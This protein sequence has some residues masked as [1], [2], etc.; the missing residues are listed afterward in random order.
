MRYRI[1]IVLTGN[2][3]Q[4]TNR[5]REI[6]DSARTFERICA[7]HEIEH[8]L[9]KANHPWTTGQ[10]QRMSR[11]IKGATV[12]RDRYDSHEQLRAHLQLV[13]D[14]YNHARRLETVRSLTPYEF[15]C[16]VWT[17]ALERL[18]LDPSHHIPEPYIEASGGLQA[19]G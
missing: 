12:K 8:A 1:N 5:K 10:V 19:G 6:W 16:Q 18:S 3:I 14:A 2:G 4:F 17:N 11:T 9:T 15:I 13:G 7:A